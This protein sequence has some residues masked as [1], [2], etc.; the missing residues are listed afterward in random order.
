MPLKFM[1]ITNNKDVALI[2]EKHG[3]DRIW[4]DLE[5]NGKEERQ[6]GQDSVKNSHTVED[7][8]RIKPLLSA[9][10]ILVRINPW[11]KE[12][13][14][15]VEE[16]VSA[17]A[18]MVMLPMWRTAEEVGEFIGAVDGRCRTMLLLETVGAEKSIGEVLTM[19]GIDEIHIG[20]NDLHLEYGLTYMFELL[21]NGKIEE[22]CG[23]IKTYG[24]PYGFGGIGR[25]GEKLCPAAEKVLLEHYRLGSSGAI[26]SRSFCNCEKM[27]DLTEV[28]RIFSTGMRVMREKEKEAEKATEKQF[29]QN[30]EEI[31]KDVAAKVSELEEGDGRKVG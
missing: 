28:E 7:I 27:K 23:K 18:D 11:S 20:M 25:I 12:S 29:L 5:T 14:K 15:E 30:K 31:T 6:R 21:A 9:S 24:I 26:L 1:Y 22:I 10:S 17:G 13:S 19:Q 3:V 8:K 4:I 2:A 16:V